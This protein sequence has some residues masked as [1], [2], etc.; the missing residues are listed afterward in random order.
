MRITIS[1]VSL[2]IAPTNCLLW[3][4]DCFTLGQVL[5]LLKRKFMNFVPAQDV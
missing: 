3:Q 1:L 2:T 4:V 5:F